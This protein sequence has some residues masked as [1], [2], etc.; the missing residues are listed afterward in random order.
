MKKNPTAV[1]VV[2]IALVRPDGRVLLQLR[3]QGKAHAGLWEFPGGKVEEGETFEQALAR[4]IEEEL[5][6]RFEPRELVEIAQAADPATTPIAITLFACRNWFGEPA[7]L[8]AE[9]IGWFA[10]EELAALAMPPLDVPLAA[11]LLGTI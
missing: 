5:G 6:I 1:P 10:A 3:P 4:E 11:A 2:A 7:A 9:T 8:D